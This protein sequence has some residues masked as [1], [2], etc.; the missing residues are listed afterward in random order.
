MTATFGAPRETDTFWDGFS[1]QSSDALVVNLTTLGP[2]TRCARH[3]DRQI[4]RCG[5]GIA[6]AHLPGEPIHHF[7]IPRK[8]GVTLCRLMPLK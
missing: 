7:L 2:T 4:L 5:T 6:I 8:L 3:G 1:R